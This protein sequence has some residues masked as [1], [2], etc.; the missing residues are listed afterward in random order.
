MGTDQ[1]RA[2]LAVVISGVILFG[3]QYFFAPPVQVA[4]AIVKT[5]T[6]KNS[7][8]T[9]TTISDNTIKSI[10]NSKVDTLKT[11]KFILK[12][13]NFYYELSNDLT[14]FNAKSSATDKEFN[15]IFTQENNNSLLFNINGVFQKALFTFSKV[16]DSSYKFSNTTL[17]I[18]GS[19]FINELGYLEYSLNSSKNFSYKFVLNEVAEELEG[20]KFKQFSYLSDDLTL[21][22]V[23]DEDKG[24]KELRWFGLDFNYHLFATIIE[25]KA[26]LF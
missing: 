5:E 9:A 14:V 25:K 17:G 22:H 21:S 8:S 7:N 19:V 15:K 13:E 26:Y 1:R 20:G 23:G 6:V 3:W 18:N 16:S 10:N 11:E 2:I 12:T 24:D 4:P